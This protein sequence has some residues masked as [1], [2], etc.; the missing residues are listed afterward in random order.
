MVRVRG[1]D[2]QTRTLGID[3][4]VAHPFRN[5]VPG[6][7]PPLVRGMYVEV[8]I[9][10]IALAGRIVVP[11]AALRDGQVFVVNKENRLEP[12]AVEIAFVQSGF[13]CIRAGLEEGER[14]VVSDLTPAVAGMLLDPVVDEES[15]A[16]LRADAAGETSIR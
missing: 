13:A 7:K 5:I 3:V 15:L 12:R 2:S 8:E 16:V 1:I 9:R 6:K 14:V 4:A 11:R 10:G